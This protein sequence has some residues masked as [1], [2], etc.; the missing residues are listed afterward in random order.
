VYELG[1]N[2]SANLQTR[3]PGERMAATRWFERSGF[4]IGYVRAAKVTIEDESRYATRTLP[5]RALHL[6]MVDDGR[7]CVVGR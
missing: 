3:G 1:S 2:E 4:E 7:D 6:E 5:P